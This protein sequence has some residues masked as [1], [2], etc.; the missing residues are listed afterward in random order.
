MAKLLP[1]S[2]GIPDPKNDAT[3]RRAKWASL[4]E[5]F[6]ELSITGKDIHWP[7]LASKYGF[8]PQTCRNRASTEKWYNEITERRR[9][10]EDILEQK[11]TERT[12]LALDK[13]NSDFATNEVSIRKRHATIARGLQVKAVA[14]L[15]EL[16][17]KEFSPRDTI[18]LLKLGLEEERFAMGLSE[19]FKG[20]IATSDQ[21]SEFKPV[22]EQ[23]GGHKK[24][25]SLGLK[26][27]QA[28]KGIDVSDVE[29]V[30]GPQGDDEDEDEDAGDEGVAAHSP[31]TPRADIQEVQGT[32]AMSPE[33][34]TGVGASIDTSVSSKPTGSGRR[35]QVASGRSR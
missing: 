20:E 28:L 16:E 19:T 30:S 26:L 7:T 5:E 27:L 8:S 32:E 6:L 3:I 13:L 35:I 2:K 12:T 9:L 25:Q 22:M 14:R 4:K 18:A 21:P 1:T 24:V 17:L 33:E 11:L 10:R 34:Y 15:R 31:I 23:M 29:D